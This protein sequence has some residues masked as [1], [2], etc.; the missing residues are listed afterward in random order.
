MHETEHVYEGS[1]W[2]AGSGVYLVD[3]DRQ[4]VSWLLA[5]L[6]KQHPGRWSGRV[7]LAVTP[8]DTVRIA[9]AAPGAS[10]GLSGHEEE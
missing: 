8:L 4:L 3:A 7:K 2:I 6:P 9:D 1:V 10:R 5:V